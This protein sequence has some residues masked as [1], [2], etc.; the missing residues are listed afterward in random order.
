M[1]VFKEEAVT[2]ETVA[3]KQTRIYKD[4]A[5]YG[6]PYNT[7]NP[8]SEITAVIESIKSLQKLDKQFPEEKN[9]VRNR[10]KWKD[11]VSVDVII[12]WEE[13]EGYY[14]GTKYSISF[15]RLSPS[16]TLIPESCDA[17]I[18][19]DIKRYKEKV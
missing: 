10:K 6:Y 19:V 4:A 1:G 9:L 7:A 17:M 11:G 3:K 13:D 15:N 2:F 16:H 8:P 18:S 5:D 14:C 12:F